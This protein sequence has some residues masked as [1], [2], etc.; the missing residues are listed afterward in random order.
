MTKKKW[1]VGAAAVLMSLGLASCSKTVATTSGG[2]ITEQQYYDKMKQT[3]AGKQVLQQMILTK[4]LEKDYGKQVTQK[5]VNSEFNAYQKRYGKN[6]DTVLQRQNLTE[7]T[8]K[9]QIRSNLLLR[10]A[11]KAN[12]TITPKMLR[13][14]WKEYQPNITVARIVVKNEDDA[15][16]II[17]QLKQNGTYANFSKLAKKNSIDNQTKNDGGKLPP[18]NNE[19]SGLDN[20]FK[21]AA[22]KLKP[23]KFTDKPVKTDYGYVVIYCIKHPAKGKMANHKQE[24]RNQII[25]EQMN[26]QATLQR[27][28]QKVLKNGNVQ[29]KDK[30]LKNILS[31]YIGGQQNPQ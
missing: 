12:T 18:F 21:D 14:Q 24:L 5:Q 22:F 3:P 31:N 23:G 9:Q 10:A 19:T 26:N 15:N 2:K 27:V 6:F 4:V 16:N 11:V 25:N 13:Q 30:D 29:I 28:A 1:L 20:T 17:N 7:A 8:F